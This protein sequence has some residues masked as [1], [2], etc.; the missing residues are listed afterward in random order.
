MSSL[1]VSLCALAHLHQ[2]GLVGLSK[3]VEELDV[4]G[5]S[6]VVGVGDKHVLDPFLEEAVKRSRPS[7]GR[8]EISVSRRAPL[9]GGVCRPLGWAKALGI[10]LGDLVLDD[11]PSCLN[12]LWVSL[13]GILGIRTRGEGVHEHGANFSLGLPEVK[14]LLGDEVQEGLRSLHL[15]QRLGLLETHARSKSTVQLQDD[16]LSKESLNF[17]RRDRSLLDVRKDR[18]IKCRRNHALGD[19]AVVATDQGLVGLLEG[20]DGGFRELLLLHKLPDVIK[21]D[22]HPAPQTLHIGVGEIDLALWSSNPLGDGMERSHNS[23]ATQVH[24]RRA[25]LSA[26]SRQKK[27]GREDH[28]RQHDRWPESGTGSLHCDD[29]GG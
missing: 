14:D 26:G 15:K 29:W 11:L 5:S 9:L 20:S 21:D 4:E 19:H 22:L 7:K 28:R 18:Q 2:E 25:L 23:S 1:L 6:Q 27:Q 24:R 16:S 3:E 8:V 13:Q 10:D 12:Q 17:V